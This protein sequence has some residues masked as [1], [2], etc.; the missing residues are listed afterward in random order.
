MSDWQGTDQLPAT[1]TL[2]DGTSIK[3]D[4][5][6]QPST[7]MHRGRETPVDLL[8][9][10]DRFLVV[11]LPSGETTLVSK[12]QIVVV[13]ANAGPLEIDPDRLA[14]SKKFTLDVHMVGGQHI[15]GAAYW[16]L[17]PTQARPQDFL[18]LSHGF[19]EITEGD[20]AHCINR[21]LVVRVNP[22]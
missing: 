11:S 21:G 10:P 6:L 14:I 13:T 2:G 3:G 4:I 1:I 5:H 7:E 8:N 9:R 17:P 16:E 22:K 12:A 19:F 15:S 20:N 18:N